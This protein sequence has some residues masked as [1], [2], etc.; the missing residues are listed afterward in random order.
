ME[1]DNNFTGAIFRNTRKKEGSKQ[2]DATGNCTI[3]GKEFYVS[4]WIKT[5]QS[6]NR[7]T[8]L[9]FT[10]KEPVSNEPSNVASD[11]FDEDLPF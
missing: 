4:G 3:D 2:P 6:G 11:D 8:S 7:F 10:P 5:S 1:Y 9:A